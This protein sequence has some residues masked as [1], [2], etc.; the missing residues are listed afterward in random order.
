M[1]ALKERHVVPV[2]A[3][4]VYCTIIVPG[5][6]LLSQALDC[7]CG[8]VARRESLELK[9][10]SGHPQSSCKASDAWV[11]PVLLSPFA[12]QTLR[13]LLPVAAQL[14]SSSCSIPQGSGGSSVQVLRGQSS[15]QAARFGRSLLVS[16]VKS[17]LWLRL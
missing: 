3:V 16:L 6:S 17:F 8:S 13:S 4:D 11:C 12:L 1:G 7:L 15:E 14:Q 5:A 10:L 9:R 2:A